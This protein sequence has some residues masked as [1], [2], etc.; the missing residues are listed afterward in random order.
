MNVDGYKVIGKWDAEFWLMEDP[1]GNEFLFSPEAKLIKRWRL[2]AWFTDK[3]PV[4][5]EEIT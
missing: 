4:W 2:G 5:C 3:L 1:D